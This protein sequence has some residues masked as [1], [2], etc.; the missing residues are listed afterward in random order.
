MISMGG[1]RLVLHGE[2]ARVGIMYVNN[3]NSLCICIRL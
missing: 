2:V 1:C 3:K